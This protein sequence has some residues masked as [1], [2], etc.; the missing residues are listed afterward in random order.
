MDVL[1]EVLQ[2]VHLEGGVY[3]RTE[4]TAPWGLHMP[5]APGAAFHAV[6][7]GG[8]WLELDGQGARIPVASGDLI[9][10]PHGHGHTLR[11]D[12]GTAATPLE[13]L[14][15]GRD[16]WE[17][18]VL[19][20]GGGGASTSLVCGGFRFGDQ[21]ANPL[22]A[23][24]PPLIHIKGEAGRA[25]PWLETTLQFIAGEAASGRPGSDTVI[26]RLSDVLFIQAVRGYLAGA[27][28]D[29]G[30]WLGALVEPGLEPALRRMHRQPERPWTVAELAAEAGMSRSA[31]SARF[32]RVVGEPP[33]QYLTRWRIHRAMGLLREGRLG[34]AEVAERVGYES[35]AAFSKAFKRWAGVA[36]GAWR[37]SV[38][39]AGLQAAS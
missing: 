11:D 5:A 8:G 39:G 18:F 25:V 26:A 2:S 17:P 24:L 21:A 29:G 20:H 13:R 7:R 28:Q 15:D 36:P 31:F 34:L 32:S 14:L 6:L 35:E 1:S 3:C 16:L 10:L 30:G 33:L 27:P 12:P 38:Q 37:R 22:L 9:V 19:H 23:V 4:L